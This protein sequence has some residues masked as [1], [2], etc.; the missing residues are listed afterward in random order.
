MSNLDFGVR[1][2]RKLILAYHENDTTPFPLPPTHSPNPALTKLLIINGNGGEF[3][4]PWITTNIVSFDSNE[5]IIAPSLSN[6]NI[7]GEG[8][9]GGLLNGEAVYCGGWPEEGEDC[10]NECFKLGDET[11]FFKMKLGRC[12]ASYVVMN[13]RLFMIGGDNDRNEDNARTTEFV[14]IDQEAFDVGPALPIDH[15]GGCA[16][17]LSPLKKF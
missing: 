1:T 2:N 15:T 3:Y 4:F 13:D 9:A 7:I 16:T 11:P 17:L 12:F 8:G 14:S 5:E 10:S 6:F